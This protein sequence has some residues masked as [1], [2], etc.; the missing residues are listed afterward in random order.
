MQAMTLKHNW[1]PKPGRRGLGGLAI[2]D[3]CQLNG[4]MA[5]KP[6]KL[7]D[8]LTTAQ[9]GGSILANRLSILARFGI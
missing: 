9:P 2:H 7:P 5:A 1:L 8:L 6:H 4:S 3:N